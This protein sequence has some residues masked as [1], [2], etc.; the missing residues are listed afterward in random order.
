MFGCEECAAH[1]GCRLGP[2]DDGGRVALDG[3]LSESGGH[4]T[5]EAGGGRLSDH[6]GYLVSYRFSWNAEV[7]AAPAPPQVAP[8]ETPQVASSDVKMSGKP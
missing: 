2:R 6:D 8:M 5:G 7:A 3:L 1:D 4:G